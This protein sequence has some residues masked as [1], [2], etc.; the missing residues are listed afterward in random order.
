MGTT[1]AP[2]YANLFVDWFKRKA[3]A[4]YPLKPLVWKRFID[5]FFCIWTHGE[6]ALEDFKNY[7]NSIHDT[8]KF[9]Y[10][11]SQSQI[12]FLDTTI[13]FDQD[14]KL[15]T[16]IY[17]KP[18]DTHLY[19]E[20]SSSHPQSVLQKGPYRQYLRLRRICTLDSDFKTNA[21]KLSTI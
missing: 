3:I 12:D 21:H 5:Y 20:H 6:Q 14:N 10:E 18:I 16:T 1:L 9:T 2:N 7:L 4:G 19:L 17:N 11:F 8:I 15:I 13:K